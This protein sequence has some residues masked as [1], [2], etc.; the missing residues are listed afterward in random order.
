MLT[1]HDPYSSLCC[2]GGEY[3]LSS[4]EGYIWPQAK[5]KGVFETFNI[6][7]SSIS[8]HRYHSNHSVFVRRT[9]SG[10]II[11]PVYVDDILLTNSDSAGLLDYAPFCDQRHGET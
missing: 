2:S 6:T 5:S 8:F 1:C 9:K 4:Q 3:S 11:L 7:I 10:V